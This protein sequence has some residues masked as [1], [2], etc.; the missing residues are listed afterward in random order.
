M[1]HI[2]LEEAANFLEIA[3]IES[4]QDFGHSVIHSGLSANGAK[5]VMINDCHGGTVLT[6]S[7]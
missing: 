2:S 1:Q 5:F 7:N 6:E 4:T 3:T